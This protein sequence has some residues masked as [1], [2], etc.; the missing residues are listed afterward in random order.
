MVDVKGTVTAGG[1]VIATTGA[2]TSLTL[3]SA[4]TSSAAEGVQ[5]SVLYT[6]VSIANVDNKSEITFDNAV[7]AGGNFIADAEGKYSVIN[8][9]TTS[10]PDSSFLATAVGINAGN[11]NAAVNI[12][13]DITAGGKIDIQANNKDVSGR[14]SVS[15][16]VGK[17]DSVITNPFE[18]K[19][20]G[21]T[22]SLFN[23]LGNWAGS[24]EFIKNHS[25]NIKKN[26]DDGDGGGGLTTELLSGD[27]FKAG[28]SIA[29][30]ADDHD[31]QVNIADNV[32]LNATNDLALNAEL[33]T[34]MLHS[35]V[36]S[37]LNNHK[38]GSDTEFGIGGALNITNVDKNAKVVVGKNV[39]L[40]G[41]N[42]AVNSTAKA[43]YNQFYAE[44]NA[45]K[46]SWTKFIETCKSFGLDFTTG[47]TDEVEEAIDELEGITDKFEYAQKMAEI[48]DKITER[49]NDYSFQQFTDTL[50]D[51]AAIYTSLKTALKT[52]LGVLDP[53]NY[54]NFYARS[55]IQ[56]DKSGDAASTAEIAGSIQIL[57]LD[58]N[59]L[60]LLGEGVKVTG[61]DK[62]DITSD[63]AIDL[64]ELTG[65]GGKYL[66][67]ADFGAGT[68]IGASVVINGVDSYAVTA[69]GKN[70]QLSAQTINVTAD[71]ELDQ[72]GII[73][74]AGM[75]GKVGVSGMMNMLY[76]DSFAITS[77]D[78]QTTINAPTAL[79]VKSNNDT[80]IIAVSGGVT[81]G[82][83]ATAAAV[84]A[85]F[86]FNNFDV[87]S[88]ATIADNSS[89][90]SVEDTTLTADEIALITAGIDQDIEDGKIDADEREIAIE[91]A[92]AAFKKNKLAN[93]HMKDVENKR[94]DAVKALRTT[95][96]DDQIEM[97][98][99]KSNDRGTINAGDITVEAITD[100]TVNSIAVEGAY[101]GDSLSAFESVNK[102][103]NGA[104]DLTNIGNSMLSYPGNKLSKMLGGKLSGWLKRGGNEQNG[105]NP[106]DAGNNPVQNGEG[107]E[108]QLNDEQLEGGDVENDGGGGD[109]DGGGEDGGGEGDYEGDQ[110]PLGLGDDASQIKVQIAGAGSL[111][112]NLGDGDT[113]AMLDNSI[114]NV[115]NLNVKS[116]DDL[117]NGAYS[118]GAAVNWSTKTRAKKSGTVGAAAAVNEGDR[119][120]DAFIANSTVSTAGDGD[121][122][123][124][125][126]KDGVDVAAAAGLVVAIKDNQE[127][128]VS[129]AAG[130]GVNLADND[131]RAMIVNSDS[132]SVDNK[133]RNLNVNA[134]SNDVQV[135]GGADVAIAL[136]TGGTTTSAT[137]SFM[138]SDID[139][140]LQAGIYNGTHNAQN[141]DISTVKSDTQVNAALSVG[142]SSSVD[143]DYH[144]GRMTNP[145]AFSGTLTL[146]EYTSTSDAFIDSATINTSSVNLLNDQQAN[147]NS[148]RQ[149]L[150]DKGLDLTGA[151]YLGDTAKEYI[152]PDETDGSVIVGAAVGVQA[153]VTF[154]HAQKLH[155]QHRSA[156]RR[157]QRQ[158]FA[159][160]RRRRSRRLLLGARRQESA[161]AA[162]GGSQ[163]N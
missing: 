129:V 110:D 45:I 130:V 67:A 148:K 155:R 10:M 35:D 138:M 7:N 69:V 97:L 58:V 4:S 116:T 135:A 37:A 80:N 82:D 92:T 81:L 84:G 124:Q 109:D 18:V 33:T 133:F 121:L 5:S 54:V 159:R 125:A 8:T 9:A 104:E 1:N 151:G 100:G 51:G 64:V 25:F 126:T 85:G 14:L 139:N 99:T 59:A 11:N 46:T 147:S 140:D 95:L 115:K 12:N 101:I 62:A 144:A 77:I 146:D 13:G 154:G 72:V 6:S 39:E 94:I 38:E 102:V 162:T 152:N 114:V 63:A 78:D 106:G 149:T 136:A 141:V 36:S 143:T 108:D 74:G 43:D 91:E 103:L 24:N 60:T 66:A 23:A 153:A 55:N 29:V 71:N 68:G 161:L 131:V 137:A 32:K 3:S 21:V 132:G 105:G 107:L 160:Q 47:G 20:D 156:R 40:T 96:T 158:T 157:F 26:S 120:V 142:V 52:T 42:V 53:A 123:V 128:N 44:M 118:G 90:Q 31:A 15:T 111:A 22:D 17:R 70:N 79:N 73:Y 88:F 41:K 48:Q 19:G 49:Y 30:L 65:V 122:N 163:S 28:M 93:D 2:S 83:K 34:A 150:L 127:T 16:N 112:I 119:K 50:T 145:Y 113:V 27:V 98:G 86:N 76:G 57:G 75:S 134:E 87:H 117:Y 56:D 89:D 61:T